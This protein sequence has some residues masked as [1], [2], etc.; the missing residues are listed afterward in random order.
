MHDVTMVPDAKTFPD[1][2]TMNDHQGSTWEEIVGAANVSDKRI[3]KAGGGGTEV[4]P[5]ASVAGMTLTSVQPAEEDVDDGT[6]VDTGIMYKGIP[7]RVFCAGSDCAVEPV[8]DDAD[9]EVT[10]VKKLTGSWFFTPADSDEEWYVASTDA[11]VTTYDRRKPC[12][13]SS[14][15][16]WLT[17]ATLRSTPTR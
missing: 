10:T 4:V 15:T 8:F 9:M 13:P 11:G 3:G 17:T 7:G 1:A 5:A 16:G 12:T 14:A 6:Q 2:V